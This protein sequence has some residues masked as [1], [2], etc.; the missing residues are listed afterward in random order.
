MIIVT[1]LGPGL[2]RKSSVNVGLVS[3]EKRWSNSPS[4]AFSWREQAGY[5]PQLPMES[6]LVPLLLLVWGARILFLILCNSGWE[7]LRTF[8]Y[9]SSI[10]CFYYLTLHNENEDIHYR[11]TAAPFQTYSCFIN[12]ERQKIVTE[13]RSRDSMRRV[14]VWK[15][16][17]IYWR[18]CTG[19][20]GWGREYNSI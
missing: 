17:M 19:V 10:T 2:T 5:S 7:Q 12:W 3:T 8:S 18:M 4:D 13:K 1:E 9:T 14:K 11:N 16:E 15:P 6:W 20:S